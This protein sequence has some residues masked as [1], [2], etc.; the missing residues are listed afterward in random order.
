MTDIQEALEGFSVEDT[1]TVIKSAIGSVLTDADYKPAKINDWSNSI[2]SAALNGLQSL[3]RPYKYAIT[4]ILMQKNGAGLVSA[5]S[6][7]WDAS[8]DGLC[9]VMWENGTMHCVVTV[10]G[11]SVNIETKEDEKLD[12]AV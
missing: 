5:A 9:K 10:Y 12:V 3:N 6:T 1:E 11:T 7:Y 4:V 8:R 2:I